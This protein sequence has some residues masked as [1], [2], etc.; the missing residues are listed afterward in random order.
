VLSP[1]EVVPDDGE[2]K[3]AIRAGKAELQPDMAFV[4]RMCRPFPPL[5]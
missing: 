1:L 5:A 4:A 2:L 3:R